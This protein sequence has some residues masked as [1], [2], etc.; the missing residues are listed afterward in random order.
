M[1]IGGSLLLYAWRAPALKGGGL[2]AP[3]SREGG[4]L[5]NNLLLATAAATVLLG[6]LYPLILDT[7]GGPKISVG[8]P[9]FNATFVPLMIPVLVAVPIGSMLAWKRGDLYAATQRMSWAFAAALVAM[10]ITAAVAWGG[11][12]LAPVV[13]GLAFFIIDMKQPGV[14][15]SR[16]MLNSSM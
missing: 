4:L 8:A 6:T 11:P 14:S 16:C 9:F 13:I 7:L 1:A 2:F 5:L 15:V 3:I 10:V 12:V